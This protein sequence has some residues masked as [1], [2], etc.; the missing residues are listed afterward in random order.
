MTQTLVAESSSL[1][2]IFPYTVP[3]VYYTVMET[4][5][6]TMTMKFSNGPYEVCRGLRNKKK[7]HCPNDYLR[8]KIRMMRMMKTILLNKEFPNDYV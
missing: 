7:T 1:L 2:Q 6:M 8:F 5:A 4:R 3:S